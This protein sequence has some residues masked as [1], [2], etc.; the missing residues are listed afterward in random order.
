[1]KLSKTASKQA[2]LVRKIG[3]AHLYKFPYQKHLCLAQVSPFS[4]VIFILFQEELV[5]LKIQEVGLDTL[6]QT[7]VITSL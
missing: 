4:L 1:M 3:D 6:L 5:M 7:K 2:H